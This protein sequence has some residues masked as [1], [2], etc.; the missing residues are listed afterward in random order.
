M[1]NAKRLALTLGYRDI[2]SDQSASIVVSETFARLYFGQENAI[3]RRL[4]GRV[5]SAPGRTT[6]SYSS[7]R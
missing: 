5:G 1:L 2:D 4:E 6:R 3:G 7:S